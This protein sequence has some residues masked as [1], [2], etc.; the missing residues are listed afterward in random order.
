KSNQ[1]SKV[2]AMAKMMEEEFSLLAYL[3]K[4]RSGGFIGEDALFGYDRRTRRI[5]G[6]QTKQEDLSVELL[7]E[8]TVSDNMIENNEMETEFE[9]E[10][11]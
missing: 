9:Y 3:V 4:N 10:D 11:F 7:E 8:E 6:L 1:Q 5:Y 2:P